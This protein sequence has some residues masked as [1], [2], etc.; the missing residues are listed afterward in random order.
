LNPSYK[1]S[2]LNRVGWAS[3]RGVT[4][5]G[6]IAAFAVTMIARD[7]IPFLSSPALLDAESKP[8][9]FDAYAKGVTSIL[10]DAQGEIEYTLEATE[11]THFLNNTTELTNPFV[12]LYKDSDVRWNIIARSGRILEASAGDEIERLDLSNDVELFQIDDFGNRMVLA[13]EFISIFP[14]QET[15]STNY[16]VALSSGDL[17]QDAVGMQVDFNQDTMTFLSQVKGRYEPQDNQP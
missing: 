13:T 7:H 16:P 4:A 10:F 2:K 9:T 12:R 3:K 6:I 8:I 15:M 14:S 5:I 11:Q 17:H 1:A